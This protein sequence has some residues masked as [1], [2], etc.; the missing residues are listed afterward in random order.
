MGKDLI[1]DLVE[2]LGPESVRHAPEDL[3]V[4][5]YDG[6]RLGDVL[7]S[8]AVL[9]T[10]AKEAARAVRICRDHG[11]PIVA[12]GSG[13]GL[14]GAA[15]P[16]DGGV[17]FSFARM[18]RVLEI[19]QRRR[20][21]R[22]QPGLI[23]ARLSEATKP[24]GLFYA[25]DPSS[26]KISSIGGNVGTNAGGPHCLSYGVTT[27]NVLGLEFVT[28]DGEVLRCR[29]DDAGYDLTGILVGSEGTLAM[30]TEIEVRLRHLPEE[31]RVFL[32][33][34]DSIEA[35]CEAVSEII[36]HGLVPTALEM[37][38]RVMIRAVEEAFHAG[39][40]Q[41]AAAVL[42]VEVAGSREGA[43]EAEHAIARIAKGGGALTWR[44][45]RTQA[46]RDALWAARKGAAGAMGRL[47]PNYYIQDAT[48]PRTRL[49]DA[50]RAVEEVA[51]HYGITVAN[52]F[53][54]G[55]GNLH[56][57]LP[58]DRRDPRQV[59]A[60]VRAGTEILKRCIDLGGTISGEHGIGYEKREALPLVFSTED[61][62]AMV[63][64][65]ETFDPRTL[66]NP[67]KIFPSG[68]S[69]AEVRPSLARTGGT[70]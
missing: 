21:A 20:R 36:G 3:R 40:P 68:A 63:R 19:D 28:N 18:N 26:Q 7:P 31:T 27:N 45:A 51:A 59:E 52:V 48:V 53:H 41:D 70:P 17:V 65:R 66:F 24:N 30:V 39:Y 12:R 61:L 55:D 4:Y 35:A 14:C 9:P 10:D 38:D 34:Y 64:L 16:E 69:C 15:V 32:A 60:V 25:P 37:M 50:L 47:A 56:P 13:T 5:A 11:V 23:N 6:Y 42:L 22:V 62:A 43:D 46:E 49:P 29:Q 58:F 57:L 44:T 54:A 33:V 1:R 8:A 67:G 2:A